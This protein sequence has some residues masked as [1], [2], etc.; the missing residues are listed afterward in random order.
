MTEE[1]SVADED[2]NV[3]TEHG[4]AEGDVALPAEAG[5][6]SEPAEVE[7]PEDREPG[8]GS[9]GELGEVEREEVP[10]P[11]DDEEHLAEVVEAQDPNAPHIQPTTV[12]SD[13]ADPDLAQDR[14]EKE[15]AEDAA[16]A[17]AEDEDPDED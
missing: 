9:P 7:D 10:E 13:L 1:V 6:G 12:G 14:G 11:S 17:D 5:V 3:D 4:A 15:A 8:A 2:E 16:A